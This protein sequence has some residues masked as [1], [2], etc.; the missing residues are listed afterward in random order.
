MTIW[1]VDGFV[2][3]NPDKMCVCVLI[4]QLPF[5]LIEICLFFYSPLNL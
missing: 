5:D 1:M 3:N 4:A 2:L